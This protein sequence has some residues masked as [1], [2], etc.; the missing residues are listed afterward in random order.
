M[1]FAYKCIRNQHLK[2][3]YIYAHAT[4]LYSCV[5]YYNFAKGVNHLRIKM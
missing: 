2:Y 5:T 3:I 1:L 4:G